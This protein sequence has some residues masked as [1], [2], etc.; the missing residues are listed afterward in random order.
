MAPRGSVRRVDGAKRVSAKSGWC[1]EGRCQEWMAPR[2]S[3]PREGAPAADDYKYFEYFRHFTQSS[4]GTVQ[5]F[6]RAAHSSRAISH[7]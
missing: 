1:Q 5:L 7:F 4:D 3:V 2:G 6:A